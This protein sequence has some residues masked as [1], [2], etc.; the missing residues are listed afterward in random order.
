[1]HRAL[2]LVALLLSLRPL[3]ATAVLSDGTANVVLGQPDF[4]TGDPGFIAQVALEQPTAA[5]IDPSTGRLF[6]ADTLHNRV[7]W[8]DTAADAANGCFATGLLGQEDFGVIAGNKGG[9]PGPST[10]SK[11]SGLFIDQNGAL[12][13]ADTGNHRV[14]RFT[15]PFTAGMAADLEIGQHDFTAIQPNRGRIQAAAD[16]LCS[17]RSVCLAGDGTLWVTDTANNRVLRYRP[18][19]ANGMAAD[20]VLGQKDFKH[21]DYNRHPKKGQP[22]QNTLAAPSSLC[23]DRE[24]NLWVADTGNNRILKY[25]VRVS[26]GMNAALI[27]GGTGKKPA[28]GTLHALPCSAGHFRY[29]RA[30]AFDEFGSLWVADEFNNRLLRFKAPF[31]TGMK[32]DTVI[33]QTDAESCQQNQGKTV[34]AASLFHPSSLS[35][36]RSGN[37]WVA[38]R[39]NNRVLGYWYSPHSSTTAGQK[40]P[41]GIVK[42]YY[43]DGTTLWTKLTYRNG[44]LDGPAVEFFR[45]GTM[46]AYRVYRNNRMDGI[47]KLFYDNGAL[48]AK[49]PFKDGVMHGTVQQ[50]TPA[51]TLAQ[52]SQF[53]NGKPEGKARIYTETGAVRSQISFVNGVAIDCT[54]NGEACLP[55]GEGL[56]DES[57]VGTPASDKQFE[58]DTP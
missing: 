12:W 23:L 57:G 50:Y 54:E 53:M 25:G 21:R 49:I 15:P 55:S 47:C 51:G 26:S 2:L 37:L 29:P 3:P 5:V 58:E 41:N 44:K 32:A 34:T 46:S 35:F 11:P 7:L 33:G 18:P 1:M 40:S 24:N 38:D 6:V 48:K 42:R 36:D 14:L 16:T 52:E 27:I 4:E 43:D 22:A 31:A 56:Q 9:L 10:L 30:L 39:S 28:T 19:L 8:W 45:N 17:P 13:V 20:S